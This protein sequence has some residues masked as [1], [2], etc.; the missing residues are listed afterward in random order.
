MKTLIITAI[1][2]AL[3]PA[4]STTAIADTIFTDNTTKQLFERIVFLLEHPPS[5]ACDK[6]KDCIKSPGPAY[7][8]S[9]GRPGSVAPS[10]PNA[11]LKVNKK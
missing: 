6:N 1:L 7:N 2:F 10:A 5:C 3:Y 9:K 11:W 4:R 8:E